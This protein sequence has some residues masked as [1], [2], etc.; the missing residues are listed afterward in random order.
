MN[1]KKKFKLVPSSKDVLRV[2]NFLIP[3]LN[4][5][6]GAE[7]GKT[8]TELVYLTLQREPENDYE[9]SF[10]AETIKKAFGKLRKKKILL[11]N[12]AWM[13]P[14]YI[15]KNNENYYFIPTHKDEIEKYIIDGLRTI[16]G[17]KKSQRMLKKFIESESFKI[18]GEM[19][20]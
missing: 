3:I 1:H 2:A 6:Y 14:V 12:N 16:E 15:S 9:S 8:M 11:T 18:K 7:N 10:R 4:E 20:E 19:K 13:F 5:S 17:I